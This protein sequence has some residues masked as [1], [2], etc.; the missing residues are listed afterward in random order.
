MIHPVPYLRGRTVHGNSISVKLIG[1]R[2]VQAVVRRHLLPLF[3]I[4]VI[5]VVMCPGKNPIWIKGRFLVCEFVEGGSRLA[6]Q[7]LACGEVG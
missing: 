6:V 1:S 7:L 4:S 2:I 3:R 5:R